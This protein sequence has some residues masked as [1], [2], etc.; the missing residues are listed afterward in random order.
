MEANPAMKKWVRILRSGDLKTGLEST[1]CTLANTCE[2]SKDRETFKNYCSTGPGAHK[3][4]NY[5]GETQ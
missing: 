5:D 3:T 2:G 1:Y 4:C